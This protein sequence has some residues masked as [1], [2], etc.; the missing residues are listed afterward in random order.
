MFSGMFA[1][2]VRVTFGVQVAMLQVRARGDVCSPR[3]IS[4]S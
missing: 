3:S 2:I 4:L 1:V